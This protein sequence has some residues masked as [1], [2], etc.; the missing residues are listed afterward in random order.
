MYRHAEERFC[1]SPT[2]EIYYHALYGVNG[3]VIYPSRGKDDQ[4]YPVVSKSNFRSTVGLK[5]CYAGSLFTGVILLQCSIRFL[6]I[7]ENSMEN[8]IFLLE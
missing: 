5:Y 8:Y 2:M 7:F 3:K 1:I 4:I 6:I